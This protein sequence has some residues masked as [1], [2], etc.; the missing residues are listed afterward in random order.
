MIVAKGRAICALCHNVFSISL[1]ARFY[2]AHL[3]D[4]EESMRSFFLSEQLVSS[5]T[6]PKFAGV[7]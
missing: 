5:D 6:K 4:G 3:R 2:V 1:K 7:E